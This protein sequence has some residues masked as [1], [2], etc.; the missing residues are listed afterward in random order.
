MDPIGVN[1]DGLQREDLS[2]ALFNQHRR[3]PQHRRQNR[4]FQL[5]T[6]S[7]G[8][9]RQCQHRTAGFPTRPTIRPRRKRAAFSRVK[10]LSQP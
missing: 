1:R 5:P 10:I 6:A 4:T 8:P 7:I 3:A 2:L 9:S